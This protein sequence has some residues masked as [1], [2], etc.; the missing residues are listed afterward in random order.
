MYD[1]FLKRRFLRYQPHASTLTSTSSSSPSL[2]FKSSP[3]LN[4]VVIYRCSRVVCLEAPYAIPPGELP[5]RTCLINLG[6]CL[7]HSQFCLILIYQKIQQA[8]YPFLSV[9]C[10]TALPHRYRRS[11]Q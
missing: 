4:I 7:V 3:T 9:A 5:G 2:D 1:S 8:L 11:A 10:T 6:N